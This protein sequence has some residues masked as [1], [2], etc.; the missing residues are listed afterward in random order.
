MD[1][2]FYFY[3]WF[4]CIHWEKGSLGELKNCEKKAP[5]LITRTWCWPSESTRPSFLPSRPRSHVSRHSFTFIA[6]DFSIPNTY[7]VGPLSLRFYV[8]NLL[9]IKGFNCLAIVVL[10]SFETPSLSPPALGTETVSIY[11][12][13]LAKPFNEFSGCCTVAAWQGAIKL[14]QTYCYCGRSF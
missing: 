1:S 14:T 5:G 11:T 4:G 10:I 8:R 7:V 12:P 2:I 6:S 9:E 13:R 3:I